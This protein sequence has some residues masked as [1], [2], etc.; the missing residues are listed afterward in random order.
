M[1]IYNKYSAKLNQL[2]DFPL[3]LIRLILAYGFYNPAKMKLS[4]MEG[5]ALWFESLGYPLPKLSAYLAAITEGA[6]VILLFFGI[7]TRVISVPLMFI[8]LVAI[9]TVHWKGGFEAANNGF[10]IPLYYFIMLFALM[11]FGGGKLSIDYILSRR[12][13]KK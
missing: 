7:A 10:E 12:F 5:I 2:K 11:I 6:G 9:F 13:N 8:M 1:R 4:N 3:L